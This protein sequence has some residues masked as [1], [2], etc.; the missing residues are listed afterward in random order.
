MRPPLSESERFPAYVAAVRFIAIVCALAF[1]AAGCGKES[2]TDATKPLQQSFEQAEPEIKQSIQ[3]V[4]VSLKAGNYNEAA[5]SLAP[6]VSGRKLT[7]PQKQAVGL[8]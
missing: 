5:K 1:F 2:K 6:V 8:A 7:E 3:A 4:T